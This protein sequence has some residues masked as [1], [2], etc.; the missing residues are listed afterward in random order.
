MCWDEMQSILRGIRKAALAASS[1]STNG[2]T[3]VSATGTPGGSVTGQKGNRDEQPAPKLLGIKD[4]AKFGSYPEQQ[5]VVNEDYTRKWLKDLARSDSFT[6][7]S[8]SSPSVTTY[9]PLRE[10]ADPVR[11]VPH[12]FRKKYLFKALVNNSIPLHRANWFVKIVYLNQVW[13]FTAGQG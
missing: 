7:T 8:S 11:R 6:S 12:G 9:I 5:T 1:I 3:P 13:P 2:S 4:V 10:L